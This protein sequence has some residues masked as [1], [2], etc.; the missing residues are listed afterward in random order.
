MVWASN[1]TLSKKYMRNS[2][3]LAKQIYSTFIYKGKYSTSITNIEILYQYLL[4][5]LSTRSQMTTSHTYSTNHTLHLKR[6][7]CTTLYQTNQLIPGTKYVQGFCFKKD[8]AGQ[9]LQLS[10]NQT[11]IVYTIRGKQII[12][13]S[14]PQQ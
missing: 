13:L 5:N 14:Y 3:L 9:L 10:Q 7:N 4:L 1:Q 8:K 2:R 6:I 11:Y 12:G